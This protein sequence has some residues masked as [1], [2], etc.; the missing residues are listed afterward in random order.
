MNEILSLG[1]WIFVLVQAAIYAIFALGLQV[2]FGLA[3]I[4]NFGH[5]ASMAVSAYTTAILVVKLGMHEALAALCGIALSVVF[6]LLMSLPSLRLRSGYFAISTLALAEMVRYVTINASSLTGGTQ[7]TSAINGSNDFASYNTWWLSFVQDCRPYFR[8]VFGGVMDGAIG[9]DLIQAT[10]FWAVAIALLF[11]LAG[12]Q[13]SP[14]GRAVKSVRDDE[15]AAAALGKRVFVYKATAFALGS[16]CGA[17]AGVFYAFQYSAF[18]PE[19]FDPLVTFF[20]Y[21]IIIMGGASRAWGVAIGALLFAVL[22]AATRFLDIWPIS[23]FSDSDRAAL[24]LVVIGLLLIAFTAWRP[25]GV[26]GK[27]EEM[28][29]E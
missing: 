19:S 4:P 14:W 24:R 20:A 28:V 16:F 5:V 6:G 17:I 3:G 9:I 7:G 23:A 11:T 21:L 8:R 2:Q 22:F 13:R 10:L 12:A 1:F 15:D 29:L 26:L 25:Q 27:R 18:S